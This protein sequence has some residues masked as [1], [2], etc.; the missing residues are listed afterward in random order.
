MRA[1]SGWY[2]R[3]APNSEDRKN[4]LTQ[5]Y[6]TGMKCKLSC[7]WDGLRVAWDERVFRIWLAICTGGILV[8]LWVGIGMTNLV[9]LVAIACMGWA[10]EIANTGIE[11]AMNI[12]HPERSYKMKVVKDLFGCVPIFLYSAYIIS[13]LIL[14]MPSL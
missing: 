4:G 11:K 3:I 6:N 8:G 9:L 7:F 2:L 14:V 10:L 1:I 12:V 5:D 13:W